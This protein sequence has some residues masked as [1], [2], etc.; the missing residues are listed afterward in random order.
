MYQ[1]KLDIIQTNIYG[2][3]IAD[4]AV[5]IA[6]LRLCFR[7]PWIMTDQNLRRYLTWTTK[8]RSATACG[9]QT[10]WAA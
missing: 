10:Q 1:R 5:N 7:G 6:R 2:V 4:F 8:L 3:D 9:V